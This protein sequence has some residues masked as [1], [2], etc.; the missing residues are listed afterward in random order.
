MKTIVIKAS[1]RLSRFRPS[2]KSRRGRQ[3]FSIVCAGGAFRGA[4]VPGSLFPI[5]GP[6]FIFPINEVSKG[7][8]GISVR[9]RSVEPLTRS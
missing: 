7:Q 8:K 4:I 9:K 1:V 3:A 6:K 5:V 2:R